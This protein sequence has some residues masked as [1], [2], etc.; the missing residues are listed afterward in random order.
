[1]RGL[2][3][4]NQ[5]F[6]SIINLKTLM[7]LNSKGTQPIHT[8]NKLVAKYFWQV[9]KQTYVN[10]KLWQPCNTIMDIYPNMMNVSQKY[11]E[12]KEPDIKYVVCFHLYKI[13]EKIN[14]WQ[15]AN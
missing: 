13:L 12:Q 2:C 7:F 11:S 9:L 5:F 14:W 8:K 10:D 4:Q 3:L 6:Y 15:K 1:M